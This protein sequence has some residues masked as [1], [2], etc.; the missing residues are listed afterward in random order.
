VNDNQPTNLFENQIMRCIICH[1]ETTLPKIL[2]MCI[3]CRKSHIAYHKSNGIIVMKSH[4]ESDHSTLLQKMLEDPTNLAPRSPLDY[5]P[6]KKRVHVSSFI[7]SGFFSSTSKF[8]K[9]GAIQVAFLEDL[10]LF[11]IKGFVV[12]S[13]VNTYNYHC[14]HIHNT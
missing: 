11:V 14:N 2:A 3:R 5:E 10:M 9:D 4:V 12:C 13:K 1:N 7:I 8:K 6:S